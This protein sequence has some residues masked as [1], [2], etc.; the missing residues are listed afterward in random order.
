MDFDARAA[1]AN[2]PDGSHIKKFADFVGPDLV[3]DVEHMRMV[4][5]LTQS[6]PREQLQDPIA[7]SR[8]DSIVAAHKELEKRPHPREWLRGPQPHIGDD[9]MDIVGQMDAMTM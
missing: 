4:L 9:A 5:T 2:L 7:R 3:C 8:F 6:L 1:V